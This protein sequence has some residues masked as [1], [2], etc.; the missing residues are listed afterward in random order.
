MK[1]KKGLE[2]VKKAI[3]DYDRDLFYKITGIKEGEKIFELSKEFYYPT[4]QL[5]KK[6]KGMPLPNEGYI[7][8]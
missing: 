5:I 8:G 1:N 6:W 7:E 2:A 4:D 3:L